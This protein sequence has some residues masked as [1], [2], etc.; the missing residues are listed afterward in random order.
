MFC[1]LD[2]S[3][4]ELEKRKLIGRAGLQLGSGIRAWHTQCSLLVVSNPLSKSQLGSN[5]PKEMVQ[6]PGQWGEWKRLA[7][8]VGHLT[9]L[10]ATFSYT[11][12]TY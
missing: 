10:E 6:T 3:G 12:S 2:W 7:M 11:F 4:I 8:R 9:Y 1:E 5:F